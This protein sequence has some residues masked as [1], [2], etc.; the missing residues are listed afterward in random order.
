M[1]LERSAVIERPSHDRMSWDN[2]RCTLPNGD[3][4][5]SQTLRAWVPE[6]MRR[7][8]R[9]PCGHVMRMRYV[10]EDTVQNFGDQEV[11]WFRDQFGMIRSHLHHPN[12]LCSPIVGSGALLIQFRQQASSIEID[13]RGHATAFAHPSINLYM[14]PAG[15]EWVRHVHAASPWR[16]VSLWYRPDVIRRLV[17]E[18]ALRNLPVSLLSFLAGKNTTPCVRSLPLTSRHQIV[19]DDMLGCRMDGSLRVLYLEAK[20][21]ELLCL[22][23]NDV[24]A[25]PPARPSPCPLSRADI[26]NLHQAKE[27]LAANYTDPPTLHDLGRKVGLNRRKLAQGFKHL[28]HVTAYEY[29]IHQ[30]MREAR[31]LLLDTE[32]TINDVAYAVGY[33]D[34]SSFTKTFKRQFGLLPRQ[35]TDHR[36]KSPTIIRAIREVATS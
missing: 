31:R 7:E 36:S 30:R 2:V 21:T 3:G 14:L 27:I 23:L 25:D 12:D 4:A 13:H 28:F 18:G 33:S 22:T 19:L 26:D 10:S 8:E 5:F 11:F 20:T 17:D 24:A 9:Y 29:C 35:F 16:T 1:I 32:M 6:T 15:A 34:P